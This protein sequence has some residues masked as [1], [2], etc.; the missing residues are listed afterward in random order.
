M[1]V[2]SECT[3][4]FQFVF[5]GK[6]RSRDPAAEA[7]ADAEVK[8]PGAEVTIPHEEYQALKRAAH[9]VEELANKRVAMAMAQVLVLFSQSVCDF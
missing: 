7:E 6:F 1:E 5:Q 2:R 3:L 8:E 9:E 4:M